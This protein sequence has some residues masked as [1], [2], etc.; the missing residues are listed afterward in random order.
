LNAKLAL[1]RIVCLDTTTLTTSVQ[2]DHYFITLDG[3]TFYAGI[4]LDFTQKTEILPA[5]CG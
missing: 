5:I 3:Y 4:K 2:M 1:T